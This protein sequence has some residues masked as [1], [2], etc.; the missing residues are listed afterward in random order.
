M[1]QCARKLIT[2][3]RCTRIQSSNF[4][5]RGFSTGRAKIQKHIIEPASVSITGTSSL[6]TMP[7]APQ[8]GRLPGLGPTFTKNCVGGEGRLRVKEVLGLPCGGESLV[9]QRVTIC[10]WIKTMRDQKQFAFVELNDGS[11]FGN[12]QCVVDSACEGFKEMVETCG[13]GASLRL[14]GMVVKAPENAKQTVEFVLKTA[15]DKVVVL[16][17]VDNSKYPLAKKR[18]GVEFL[19][20]IA[21]LRPRSNI[22]GAVARVRSGMAMATHDFFQSRG[23]LYVHTPLITGADCEGAGEMFGVTT[24][25]KDAEEKGGQ[26]PMKDG[27]IDFSKDFFGKETNLTVSGQLQVENYC[28]GLS[29]VYT[30]GPTF[31][32][33][34]SFTY[35][36]LAEFWMIEPEL[37]F[38]D[39]RDVRKQKFNS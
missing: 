26:L 14:T 34:E 10:G 35:K 5:T 28:V 9:G 4:S 13:T 30:F 21:H 29:D 39:L 12:L 16:G 6:N 19:R 2:G 38:A 20:T 8:I 18:H 24:M 22:I 36:H 11:C 27:K 31:R 1:Q 7:S 3:L 25:L 15:E 23:F 17:C 37:A 33:E 32:A